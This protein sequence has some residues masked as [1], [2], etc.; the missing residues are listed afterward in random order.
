MAEAP[1][2]RGN[3]WLAIGGGAMTAGGLLIGFTL[4]AS[5]SPSA[6]R[7]ALFAFGCF[8]AL[9]GFIAFMT[10]IVLHV[11]HP[12][13]VRHAEKWTAAQHPPGRATPPTLTPVAPKSHTGYGQDLERLRSK[14]A[15]LLARAPSGVLE[16][17]PS[18][19]ADDIGAW[20][21]EVSIKFENRPE[22]QRTFMSEIPVGL[23][24]LDNPVTRRI[25]HRLKMLDAILQSGA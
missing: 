22:C 20:E 1:P 21:R 17:A 11:A 12:L 8:V 2:N 18:G 6:P 4:P 19:L 9:V 15:L 24:T 13:A 14:G 25:E 5:G 16:Q 10:G 7:L 3:L 23:P